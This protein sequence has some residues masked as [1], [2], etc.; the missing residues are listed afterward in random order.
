M[1]TINQMKKYEIMTITNLDLGDTAAEDL[2]NTVR[3]LIAVQNGKVL[4]SKFWGKRKFAY[5]I[6]K[7]TEGY[8]D[9]IS[10]ELPPVNIK[11]LS[12]KLNLVNGL[13]RYLISAV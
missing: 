6:N 12:S 1:Y 8:Y 2:S 5:E 3:D 10:F 9:V 11:Q 13:E 4:D 7:K